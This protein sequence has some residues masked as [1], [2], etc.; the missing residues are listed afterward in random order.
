MN[1]LLTCGGWSKNGIGEIELDGKYPHWGLVLFFSETGV[2]CVCIPMYADDLQIKLYDKALPLTLIIT[3]KIKPNSCQSG[4]HCLFR[5][6]ALA[7]KP[8][9]ELHEETV[10]WHFTAALLWL[11]LPRAMTA[12]PHLFTITHP[13]WVK[14]SHNSSRPHHSTSASSWPCYTPC[15][16]HQITFVQSSSGSH[17]GRDDSKEK[18]TTQ[19]RLFLWYSY[20]LTSVHN[21]FGTL[22]D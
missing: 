10:R 2:A 12:L 22:V 17:M 15:R 20:R 19:K 11:C 8:V 5:N 7:L 4:T 13:C 16:T 18:K 3:R 21:T 14:P 6:P 9:C 1:Y